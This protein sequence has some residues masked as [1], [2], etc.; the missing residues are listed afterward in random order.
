MKNSTIYL[1]FIFGIITT[2]FGLITLSIYVSLFYFSSAIEDLL[3]ITMNFSMTFLFTAVSLTLS[4]IMIGIYSI[5]RT[6][7]EYYLM[8]ILISFIFSS[9]SLGI[10]LYEMAVRGP[11]WLGLELFGELGNRIETMYIV[12]ALFLYNFLLEMINA[13]FL[14][15]EIKGGE[16]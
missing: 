16:K 15:Y 9:I 1:M 11:T 14:W 13:T 8:W 6:H 2:V 4:G 7:S 10:Q 3:G 12:G 5:S